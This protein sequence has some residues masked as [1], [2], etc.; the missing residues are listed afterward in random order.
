V[1]N[2]F[3][4]KAFVGAVIP[5]FSSLRVDTLEVIVAAETL[6]QVQTTY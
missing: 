4:T 2:N 1:I 3:S 5:N 6:D